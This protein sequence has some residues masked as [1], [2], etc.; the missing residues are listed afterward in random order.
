MSRTHEGPSP[1]GRGIAETMPSDPS[2]RSIEIDFPDPAPP[3]REAL[4][5]AEAIC[6]VAAR[7]ALRRAAPELRRAELA[8]LL[9]QDDAVRALNRQWRGNDRP[10]NVL[11]FP[12]GAAAAMASLLGDI[13]L[14]FETV[15]GEA[16]DQGKT[17]ANH[18]RHLVVHATLHLL[19]HD[20]VGE[21]DAARM[22]RLEIEILAELGVADPYRVVEVGRG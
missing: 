19:G 4:P 1:H 5:E 15:A 20:H 10:T 12:A 17:L 11:A 14:A 16:R 7:A 9:A 13:V 22:E 8:V 3:W 6:G 18:L 21:D 2:S